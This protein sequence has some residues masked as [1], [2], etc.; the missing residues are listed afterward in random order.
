L[1]GKFLEHRHPVSLITKGTLMRRDLDLLGALAERGLVSVAVSIPTADN[2]LKRLLEP[3]VPAAAERFRL[4]AELHAAKVPV[5]VMMAPIIPALNDGEIEHIVA[6]AADAGADNAAWILL[7]LPHELKALFRDWLSLHYPDRAA[8][9]MSLVRQSSG[10]RDYDNRFGV[11]QTGTGEYASM[12]GQRFRA[13]CQRNGL[14]RR[15]QRGQPD[16]TQFI[17]PS[18]EQISLPF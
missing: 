11:R 8:R 12:I 2:A 1:L 7:R 5:S 10:G 9:V 4:V 13:A 18:G 17:R 14:N 15:P 16:C 3:R 6:R